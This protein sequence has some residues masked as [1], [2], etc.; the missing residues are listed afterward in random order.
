MPPFM[1]KNRVKYY[2]KEEEDESKANMLEEVFSFE[3]EA[4]VEEINSLCSH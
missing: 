4:K 1:Y 2:A 3:K